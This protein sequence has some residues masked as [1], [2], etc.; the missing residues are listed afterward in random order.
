MADDKQSKSNSSK[1]LVVRKKRE[2]IRERA[3]KSEAKAGKAPR[4]RKFASAVGGRASK[5]GG[6]LQKE[7]TP[8]K[9]NN[10]KVGR[11]LGK[12][13]RLTPMYFVNAAREMKM[14]TWPS[15]RMVAK[16][17]TAVFLFSFFLSALVKAMDYGFDKLFKNVILK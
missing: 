2:T 11:A 5:V 17:T 3:D 15:A 8:L 4:T 13:S 7:Y 14:V 10:S 16:L 6:F 12:K 9:M 1:K